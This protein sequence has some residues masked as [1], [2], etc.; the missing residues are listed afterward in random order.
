MDVKKQIVDFFIPRNK[1][2][3]SIILFVLSIVFSFISI[4][5]FPADSRYNIS[6]DMSPVFMMQYFCIGLFNIL[7]VV[8]LGCFCFSLVRKHRMNKSMK[9]IHDELLKKAYSELLNLTKYNSVSM[10]GAVLTSSFL[11][12]KT[13][14]IIPVDKI[15]WIYQHK[16][17][18]RYFLI[19]MRAEISMVICTDDK[20]YMVQLTKKE[21]KETINKF[22]MMVLEAN[23]NIMIGYSESNEQLYHAILKQK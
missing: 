20:K 13:G 15:I 4:I 22:V 8:S 11:F 1:I 16:L 9:F 2:M 18:Y 17:V 23:S 14:Y 21:R 5:C 6:P 3:L 19:P 7:V 12:I 10:K